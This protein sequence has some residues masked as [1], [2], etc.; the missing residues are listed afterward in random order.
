VS[1]ANVERV[2]GRLMTDEG[3][4]R[5]FASDA[6]ATLEELTARGLAL[7]ACEVRGLASLDPRRIARLADAIDPRLQKT[8][9]CTGRKEDTES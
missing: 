6:R 7:T 5:R 1:H 2:I 9:L 3:F 4:R 8:D